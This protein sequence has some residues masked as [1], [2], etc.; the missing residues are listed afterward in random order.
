MKEYMREC[1]QPRCCHPGSELNTEE[2]AS[3]APALAALCV[4]AV[5][6][7]SCLGLLLFMHCLPRCT[8][9]PDNP[10]LQA[11]LSGI[12]I[13]HTEVTT[14]VYLQVAGVN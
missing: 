10:V 4:L 13:Q 14:A 12:W 11:A 2:K 9:S 1:E 3:R 8:V 7:I 6:A 5:A